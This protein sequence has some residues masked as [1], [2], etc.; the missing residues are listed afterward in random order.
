MPDEVL[1]DQF[2]NQAAPTQ[3]NQ[4]WGGLAPEQQ[5]EYGQLQSEGLQKQ[6]MQRHISNLNDD[7]LDMAILS[8]FNDLRNQNEQR[9]Q[10]RI[11]ADPFKATRDKNLSPGERVGSSLAQPSTLW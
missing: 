8:E 4:G 1:M 11:Q 9:I 3:L 10:K 2:Q 7:Q 5:L 6:A